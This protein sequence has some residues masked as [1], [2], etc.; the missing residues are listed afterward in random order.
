M[1][2]E[3]LVGAATPLTLSKIFTK[4][5]GRGWRYYAYHHKLIL[6]GQYKELFDFACK[7][8]IIRPKTLERRIIIIAGKK[9][10]LMGYYVTKVIEVE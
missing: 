7:F 1:N 9:A 5:Y 10:K 2:E 8:E 6:D 3:V 4:G